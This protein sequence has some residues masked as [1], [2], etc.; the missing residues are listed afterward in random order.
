[1]SDKKKDA[2]LIS[3]K[4]HIQHLRSLEDSDRIR[5]ACVTY[6]QNWLDS[7]YPERPDIVAEL[8]NLAVQL[9][10]HLEVPH[11]RW[12]YAWMKPIFGFR[13]AKR[14][15]MTLPQVKASLVRRWDKAMYRLETREAVVSHAANA[16]NVTRKD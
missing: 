9:G 6:V 5:K 4:L 11:L 1:M 10:G 3:M 14:V 13:A 2:M 8:Q 7:F 16:V 12:K 15:Q